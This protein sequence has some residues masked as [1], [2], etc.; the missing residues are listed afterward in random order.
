[1]ISCGYSLV[2]L[3]QVNVKLFTYRG[4]QSNLNIYS[5]DSL[6]IRGDFKSIK[7]DIIIDRNNTSP[8]YIAVKIS[9]HLPIGAYQLVIEDCFI[10]KITLLDSI[11]NLTT[12]AIFPFQSRSIDFN[13]PVFSIDKK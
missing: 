13:Y 2:A 4:D 5:L 1:L 8:L 10:D 9:D 3:D 11:N 12:G 6:F 7:G